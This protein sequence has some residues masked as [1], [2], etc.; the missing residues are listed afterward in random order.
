MNEEIKKFEEIIKPEDRL[1]EELEDI[2]GGGIVCD[3][4]ASCTVGYID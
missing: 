3:S 2:L 4:G 1:N